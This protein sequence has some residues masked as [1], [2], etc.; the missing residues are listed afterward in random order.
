MEAGAGGRHAKHTHQRAGPR[1][2]LRRPARER[3]SAPDHLPAQDQAPPRRHLAF[4]RRL[5]PGRDGAPLRV[6][7]LEVSPP[8]PTP[9]RF[10]SQRSRRSRPM[11]ATQ[12][13]TGKETIQDPHRH[14][15]AAI[16]G[17]ME[18][19]VA[20][21]AAKTGKSREA[22]ER[23]RR[24]VPGGVSG[25]FRLM[26]PYPMFAARARGSRLFDLDGNEYI[27]FM[28]NMGSQLVGHAHPA[29]VK[30]LGE[31]AERGTLFCMPHVWEQEVAR[32]LASRFGIPQWRYVNTGTEATMTALRI[33]RGYTG[34]KYIVKFEG[35]YHGHHD[36]TLVT[37]NA[38]LR[39][40]GRADRGVRVP[41]SQGIPEETYALT[42][43][44]IFNNIDS[45]K[46]LFAR[47]G[48]EIAAVIAEPIMM[49][50]GCIEPEPG[51][52][53]AVRDLC[54]DNGALLIY[55]EVKTGC[56]VAP[57]GA[58]E[59]YG[60][61]PD[62]VCVAKALAGGLPLGAVG[63]SEEVMQVVGDG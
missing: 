61:V 62:I 24:N 3:V 5:F 47:H 27:D 36:Q 15:P 9:K 26:N 32:Q 16:R 63:G 49:D 29:V 10:R 54:H 21:W 6:P 55:D 41:A 22:W 12:Q 18:R 17:E 42:L 56:K 39:Q 48:G 19:Q 2:H 30:A 43:M 11:P 57:G 31:Q 60:V 44:A 4:P 8:R 34:K 28:L 1:R 46:D 53:A 13:E 59:L 25:N 52:F 35:H 50:C 20:A 23:A 58:S 14:N 38:L 37:T 40:L 7:T 51:F 33:A 45:V